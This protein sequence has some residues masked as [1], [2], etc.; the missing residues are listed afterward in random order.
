MYLFLCL[1]PTLI[2]SEA[3]SHA[4][5]VEYVSKPF[6]IIIFDESLRMQSFENKHMS[7][8]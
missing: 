7:D 3:T 6:D 8:L 5:F 1:G 2:G 4:V